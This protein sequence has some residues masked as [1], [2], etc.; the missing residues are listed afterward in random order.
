MALL[1]AQENSAS[2]PPLS[3][4]LN[5]KDQLLNK[6]VKELE[7]EIVDLNVHKNTIIENLMNTTNEC[8]LKDA[9]IRQ[10]KRSM[11]DLTEKIESM[12]SLAEQTSGVKVALARR[13]EG[14]LG[15]KK[16][17]KL[18]VCFVFFAN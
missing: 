17:D 2:P 13:V 14:W 15:L 3:S 6:R 4:P 9:E 16:E 5:N 1:L 12:A 7:A 11:L 8:N 18:F 10:L